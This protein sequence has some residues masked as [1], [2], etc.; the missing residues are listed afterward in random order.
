MYLKEHPFREKWE[1]SKSH[2]PDSYKDTILEFIN[3]FYPNAKNILD[4]GM[5]NGLLVKKLRKSGKRAIGID[6]R[7]KT[8]EGL[9]LADARQLPFQDEVFDIVTEAYLLADMKDFQQ[10]PFSELEKVILEARRVLKVGGIFITTPNPHLSEQYF[11]K[12]LLKEG[13][14]WGVYQK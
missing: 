13:L 10:L 7:V 4:L 9:I 1:N 12:T 11:N 8:S 2:G 14:I 3:Q 5:C 6:L